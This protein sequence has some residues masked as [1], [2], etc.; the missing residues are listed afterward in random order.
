[1]SNLKAL[2]PSS[3]YCSSSP[4]SSESN[5][6][7]PSG[8]RIFRRRVAINLRASRAHDIT[9]LITRYTVPSSATEAQRFHNINARSASKKMRCYNYAAADYDSAF[10]QKRRPCDV[11]LIR[12]VLRPY[13]YQCPLPKSFDLRIPITPKATTGSPLWGASRSPKSVLPC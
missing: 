7:R 9:A 8:M 6:R 2:L 13:F 3:F 12:R 4:D 11:C 1:M 10:R 5:L